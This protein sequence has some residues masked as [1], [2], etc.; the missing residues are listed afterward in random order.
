MS[1][2]EHSGE[3]AVPGASPLEPEPGEAPTP[4]KRPGCGVLLLGL[5][6]MAGAA[7]LLTLLTS[8]IWPGETKLT[9]PLFC[10]DHRPD[11][12]VVVDSYSSAPGE[13]SYDFSLY[14]MGDRGDVTEVGWFRPLAVVFLA[15]WGLLVGGFVL[16]GVL[17]GLRQRMR[18]ARVVVGP[19]PLR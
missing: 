17:A 2:S 14:C 19:P 4:K 7:L 8:V 10:P 15:H 18:R 1:T 3:L 16:A 11:A 12:F 9:A 6:V 13:T 5:A